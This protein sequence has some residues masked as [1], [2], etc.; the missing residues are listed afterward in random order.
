MEKLLR[1][2]TVYYRSQVLEQLHRWQPDTRE[3]MGVTD[4]S[5]LDEHTGTRS[6]NTFLLQGLQCS[7]VTKL[8]IVPAVKEKI[9]E[10]PGSLFME[11]TKRIKRS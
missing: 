1:L 2:P 6:K 5:L 11:Q 9:F 4:G 8:N 3:T 10:E 7:L